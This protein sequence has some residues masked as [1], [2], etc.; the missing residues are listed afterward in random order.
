V[1][2]SDQ[3]IAADLTKAVCS[4]WLEKRPP[5]KAADVGT[6]VAEIYRILFEA[7]KKAGE[8]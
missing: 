6:A 5:D 1:S 8:L 3:E 7:V 2:Q 4:V